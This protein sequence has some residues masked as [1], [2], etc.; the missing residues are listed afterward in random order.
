[1]RCGGHLPRYEADLARRFPSGWGFALA[2][3]Y[4]NSPTASGV[5]S[6]YSNT[7]A[8]AQLSY[9]PTN[10]LGLQYQLIRSRPN[11][12]ASTVNDVTANDTIGQGF[13]ATRTDAQARLSLRAREDG[14]RP[15]LH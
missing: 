7:Q 9:L 13:H 12:R 14:T 8:L 4:L 5:S 11:R 1:A 3:D 15:A 10:H 6:S 2:G